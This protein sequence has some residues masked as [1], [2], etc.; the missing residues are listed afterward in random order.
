ML[1]VSCKIVTHSSPEP[2]KTATGLNSFPV[3]LLCG[4]PWEVGEELLEFHSQDQSLASKL[5]GF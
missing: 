2:L 3:M 5:S 1:S 4:L